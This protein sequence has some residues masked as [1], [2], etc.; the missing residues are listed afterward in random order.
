MRFEETLYVV[1]GV[2]LLALVGIGLIILGDYTIGDIV[3]L[4][5]IIWGV[6]IYY[7]LDY[8]SKDKGEEE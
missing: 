1:S 7:F 2:I 4:L 3:L 8:V 6:F 5:S